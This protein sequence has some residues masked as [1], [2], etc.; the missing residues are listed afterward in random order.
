MCVQRDFEAIRFFI[1]TMLSRIR[2]QSC[3]HSHSHIRNIQGLLFNNRG[4]TQC[5]KFVT[6]RNSDLILTG[7]AIDCHDLILIYAIRSHT[8]VLHF[9]LLIGMSYVRFHFMYFFILF[10][11][12][13]MF[14]LVCNFWGVY[15]DVLSLNMTLVPT[16]SYIFNI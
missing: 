6:T 4:C 11:K 2:L 5:C 3:S 13:I 1:V 16:K 15:L 7:M 12:K 8:H 9:A 14:S 10:L